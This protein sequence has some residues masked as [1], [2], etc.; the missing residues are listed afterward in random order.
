MAG[1]TNPPFRRLCR[2]FGAGLYVS[3]MITSRGLVEGGARTEHLARFAPD[4][5]PRSIQLYGTDPQVMGEAV[6]RLVGE[7]RVDH[8][9][10]N[11]G[12]PAKKI[13]RHGGGAALPVKRRL[14]AEI[15][16]AAVRSAAGVPVTVKFRKGIDDSL[17]TYLD[18]GRIAEAEGVAAVAL[19]ARTA[20]QLYSG[21]ADWSAIAAL[22]EAV[23]TVPV[24]GNGDVWRGED[25]VAM[26]AATGCDGVVVGRGCLGR[27]WLFR[28]LVD[29][30][31]G[32]PTQPAPCLGTVVDVMLDH[33]A[34]QAEWFG[35]DGVRDFRKHTAW[36]LRGY[37]VGGPTRHAFSQV[38]SFA[39]LTDRA[40]ALDRAI[41]PLP[42]TDGQPR[43]HVGGPRRVTLPQGWLD[44]RDT[45]TPV[46]ADAEMLVSGG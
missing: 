21:A 44:D 34:F 24:L 35:P 17:L 6:R 16:G 4:E 27:P 25:A 1:V 14:Y 30:F 12:C 31:A 20:E 15:V 9:D 23:T 26:V 10:L 40:R 11:F 29:A 33:A 7:G 28:D 18:A 37:P 2:Q 43:G 13:T 41:A 22:K 8:I 42:G 36:Y 5:H 38:G 3:E 19:H 46:D 39:E 32:R 45:H